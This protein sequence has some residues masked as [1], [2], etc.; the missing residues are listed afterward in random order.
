MAKDADLTTL[1]PRRIVL[2]KPSALGDIAH[3]LPVLSALRR[4]YPNAHIA[5][6][7]NKIYE[8]ILRPHPDLNEIIPFD[9]GVT[10][11]GIV[12]SIQSWWQFSRELRSKQFDLAIDLQGLLRTGLMMRATRAPVRIGLAS[13]REGSRWCY[14][15]VI[16]DDLQGMHA[17][18]RYWMIAER[19]G[20][21]DGG[22]QFVLP[23]DGDAKA[24]AQQQLASLPRPWIA[25]GVG[26]RWLTKRWPPEHFASLVNQALAQF[27]GS[28]ILVGT[29][30]EK[31]LAEQAAGA[32]VGP[33]LNVAGTT[34]LPQLAAM[35]GECDLMVG[36]DTGPLHLAVALGRPVVAPFTCTRV[37]RTG[38][39]GPAS[40]AVE[41]TVWCAGSYVKTC[42]RL[43]CMRELT[44]SRLWPSFQE[45]LTAW[46]AQHA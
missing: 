23:V 45:V 32:I 16:P 42:D 14:T 46:R 33:K 31:S 28:A 22:K 10:K 35:L 1:E 11:R 15:H 13:A 38:P 40:R 34:T 44:P 20:A 27:G 9:R 30:D 8:P 39:Y 29:P 3:S 36:N 12:A 7:V 25:V 4:R 43:D 21:A 19:L 18:D 26:A 5:W 2:I 37:R 17:V 41:T 24:W 6:V